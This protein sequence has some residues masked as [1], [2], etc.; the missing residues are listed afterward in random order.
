[1][2]ALIFF[3]ACMKKALYVFPKEIIEGRFSLLNFYRLKRISASTSLTLNHSIFRHRIYL[4]KKRFS[5][6]H[7]LQTLCFLYALYSLLYIYTQDNRCFS[8][9]PVYIFQQ[10]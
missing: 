10:V 5:R 1:M 6:K 7:R 3:S 4:L 2:A 8:F 9:Q